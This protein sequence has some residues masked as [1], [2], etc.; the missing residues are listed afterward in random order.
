[1]TRDDRYYLPPSKWLRVFSLGYTEAAADLVWGR[2]ILYFGEKMAGNSDEGASAYFM[3]YLLSAVDLDPKFRSCYTDGSTL[4]LFQNHGRVTMKSIQMALDLLERGISAFPDD[5][6]IFFTLGFM[7]YYEMRRFLPDDDSDP[8]TRR[9]SAL[10]RYYIGR[11]ALM[12]GAPPYATML[13]ASLMMRSGIDEAVLDHLKSMLLQE[14]DESVRAELI[15]KIRAALG[16]TVENDIAETEKLQ[17]DWKK[18]MPY[19]PYDFY[20]LLQTDT[21]SA[22]RLDP[23]YYTNR[24]LGLTQEDAQEEGD[25]SDSSRLPD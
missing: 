21:P 24:L 13:S 1:M 7:H 25:V 18:K 6:E 10:G 5:G 20:L 2:T 14:T 9:H 17:A 23:L 8:E 12:K 16:K 3:N 4:T 15:A 11:S 22:E 19:V